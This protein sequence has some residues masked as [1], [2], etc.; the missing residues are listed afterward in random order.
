LQDNRRYSQ[1][2]GL[3]EALVV[4]AQGAWVGLDNNDGPRADG[5]ERPIIWRFAAPDGGWNAS[6]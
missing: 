4:D 6:P 5:E 1:A 2:Y 3:A